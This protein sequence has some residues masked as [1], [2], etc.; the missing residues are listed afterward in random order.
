MQVRILGY[1]FS[2]RF[3]ILD[4]MEALPEASQSWM[5]FPVVRICP[6]ACLLEGLLTAPGMERKPKQAREVQQQQP[7]I[8]MRLMLEEKV[9]P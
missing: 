7:V 8:Q 5:R 6:E 1:L 3:V 4:K 2:G 9:E